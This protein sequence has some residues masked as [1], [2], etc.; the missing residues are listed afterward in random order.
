MALVR[1]GEGEIGAYGASCLGM[2]LGARLETEC[3][4][5]P[6]GPR[7]ILN[8]PFSSSGSGV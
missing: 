8:G 5:R 3:G 6:R 4:L 1:A 2:V 7:L